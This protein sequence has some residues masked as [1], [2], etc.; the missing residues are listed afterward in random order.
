MF[1]DLVEKYPEIE[2]PVMPY[3]SGYEYEDRLQ[4][5]EALRN[6]TLK[7]VISTSAL[8]LGVDLPEL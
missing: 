7:G 8:E 2:G 1:I 6:S 3:R 5:E 4:I